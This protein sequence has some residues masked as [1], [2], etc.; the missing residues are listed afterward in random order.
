MELTPDK[1]LTLA[2]SVSKPTNEV[3]IHIECQ[4]ETPAQYPCC[5]GSASEK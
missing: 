5:V 4:C 3:V 1:F 2:V